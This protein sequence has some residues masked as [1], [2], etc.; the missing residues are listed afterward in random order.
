M[1]LH[2]AHFIRI[3]Y[4]PITLCT[5]LC[6]LGCGDISTGGTIQATVLNE[7]A[8]IGKI[9][10]QATFVGQNSKSVSGSATVYSVESTGS[11]VLRI[12]N[13]SAPNV[14]G[15]TVVGLT[16][17][18]TVLSR[19]LKST[20]GNQNYTTSAVATDQ[21][22]SVQIYSPSSQLTYAVANF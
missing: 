8:P 9:L 21:W 17:T 20:R 12:E 1:S 7:G 16:Q 4:G 11:V 2:L 6:Q 15:L 14:S 18:D 13:L 22:S 3:A 10:A 19:S 5:I